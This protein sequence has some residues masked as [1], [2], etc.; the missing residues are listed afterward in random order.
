MG[1]AS[2]QGKPRLV[3][4]ALGLTLKLDM[5]THEGR[6][7]PGQRDHARQ[8]QLFGVRVSL[9]RVHVQAQVQVRSGE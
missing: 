6:T 2:T 3:C 5:R 8:G 4:A 9:P 7:R 1:Q